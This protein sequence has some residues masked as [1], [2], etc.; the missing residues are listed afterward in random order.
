[1]Q[2]GRVP[3]DLRSVDAQMRGGRAVEALGDEDFVGFGGGDPLRRDWSG[4]R[5][6]CELW[7]G[8]GLR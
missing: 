6:S 8:R 1:M 3:G 5:V 2:H 7:G 4:A